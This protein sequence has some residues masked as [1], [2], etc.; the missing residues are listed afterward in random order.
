MPENRLKIKPAAVCTVLVHRV[1]AIA[2]TWNSEVPQL[3]GFRVFRDSFV[4]Q[5]TAIRTYARVRN[6]KNPHTGT[7]V[8]AQYW[9][10]PP[11][12]EPVK[13]TII[14][15]PPQGLRRAELGAI[16]GQFTRAR[17][18][19]VELAL[20]FS[21]DGEVDRAFVLRHGL[22]GRSRLV[23]GSAFGDLRFGTRHSA[24]MVRCYEKPEMKCYRVEL[25]LHS[26]WLRENQLAKPEDVSE[27]ASL[28]LPGRLQFVRIDWDALS[29]YLSRKGL[30]AE[31][32]IREARSRAKSLGRALGYLRSDVGLCNVH[33]FLR[34]LRINSTI[35]QQ[36]RA[37]ADAWRRSLASKPGAKSEQSEN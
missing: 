12:L 20:N 3:P 18:L 7:T 23:E 21:D 28:L 10:R 26:W 4:R 22:F 37:W 34:P 6:F 33:R 9:A 15:R 25:E 36:L 11:W 29:E 16:C 35:E 1:Q 8:D 30:P 24:T 14:P 19:T 27:L 32:I 5:Q 13:L 17:L 2:R 31:T